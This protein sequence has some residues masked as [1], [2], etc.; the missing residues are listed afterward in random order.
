MKELWKILAY[1]LIGVLLCL[2]VYQ[3]HRGRTSLPIGVYTDTLTVVDTIPYYKPVPRDSVVIRYVT[4]TLPVVDDVPKTTENDRKTTESVLN[5]RDSVENF[6]KSV[7][8]SATVEIPI[9]QK[10]YRDSSYTAYV[11]GFRPNLDSIMIYA[12]VRTVRIKDKPKRWGIGVQVGYGVT[13]TKQPQFAPYI[14]IGV[15]YNLWNF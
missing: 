8:D 5:S 11:S 15:S 6:S 2:N 4:Q 9:T 10:V 3:C 13:V 1:T 12:P 14:G 7:P